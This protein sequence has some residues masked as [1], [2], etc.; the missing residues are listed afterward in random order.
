M[1]KALLVYFPKLPQTKYFSAAEHEYFSSI[2]VW[3]NK[4]IVF[5][6]I[7][8]QEENL[9]MSYQHPV[10]LVLN[11]VNTIKVCYKIY[12][13]YS[14]KEDASIQYELYPTSSGSCNVTAQLSRNN[15]VISPKLIDPG[16]I[17]TSKINNHQISIDGKSWFTGNTNQ[18]NFVTDVNITEP[19]IL[20][21][22][23]KKIFVSSD[24]V[25]YDHIQISL[26]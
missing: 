9:P 24:Q 20:E 16:Y 14:F 2:S 5:S 3:F 18:H 25:H 26:I 15:N 13:N 17:I 6:N 21:T 11:S 19:L 23:S 7:N 12:T 22:I 8:D 1:K 10:D 4:N